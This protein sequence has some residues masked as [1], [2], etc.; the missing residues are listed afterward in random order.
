VKSL[1]VTG[2]TGFIGGHL[3]KLLDREPIDVTSLIY[4]D[5]KKMGDLLSDSNRKYWLDL[6]KPDMVVHLAWN[7]TGADDYDTD[8]RNLIWGLKSSM[9]MDECT[10]RGIRFI[11]CGSAVD[12]INGKSSETYYQIAKMRMRAHFETSVEYSPHAWLRPQYVVSFEEKRPTLVRDYF[13]EVS[14]NREFVMLNPT[15]KLDFVHVDDVVSGIRYVMQHDITGVV[16]LGSG[17]LHEVGDLVASLDR[18]RRGRTP[19]EA[20]ATIPRESGLAPIQLVKY[21][22]DPKSTKQIFRL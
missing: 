11:G 13:K 7:D 20:S 15:Q 6:I 19:H 5:R 14:E 21:G 9:F 3:R 22:W 18:W 8:S 2:D 12:S 10:I 17:F 1:L 4:W 16:E